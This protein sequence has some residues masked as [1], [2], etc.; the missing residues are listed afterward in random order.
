MNLLCN[1]KI[2]GEP[3]IGIHSYRLGPF[4][5]VDIIFTILAA[6]L[7]LYFF[8]DI[9]FI[10]IFIGLWIIGEIFH[11]LFCV[12]TTFWRFIKNI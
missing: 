3:R 2:F 5:L 4:A 6:L 12:D 9:G 7:I 8:Q 11:G 10:K 1:V